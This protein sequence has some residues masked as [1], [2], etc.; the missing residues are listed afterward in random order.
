MGVPRKAQKD[1]N[2]SWLQIRSIMLTD[3]T[4]SSAHLH[5][6]QVLLSDSSFPPY[7][8]TFNA[9]LFLEETLPNIKPFGYVMVPAVH[10][11]GASPSTMDQIMQII[12]LD[13]F[14]K[15]TTLV[16]N[17]EEYRLAVRGRVGLKQRGLRK[18]T[19]DYN[20]VVTLKGKFHFC[21]R[22]F[23]HRRLTNGFS[24]LN[25]LKGF[26]V[27]EFHVLTKPDLD[28]VNMVGKVSI[29]N[30]SVMTLAMVRSLSAQFYLGIPSRCLLTIWDRAT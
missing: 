10:S 9:S 27:T 19:V 2:N 30:P 15:Y 11:T 29:P 13:Q 4:P 17:S 22:H 14:T 5:Q 21:Y 23:I 26:N 16:L 7:L 8:D 24:G 3:P 25:K 6:E 12:N 1:V 18:I 28:G 20:E